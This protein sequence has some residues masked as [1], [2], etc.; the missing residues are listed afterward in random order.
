MI[1]QKQIN[2]SIESVKNAIFNCLPTP[3]DN[4]FKLT[5]VID[6]PML[7]QL[8][9]YITTVDLSKWQGVRPGTLRKVISWNGD[10]VIEELHLVFEGVTGLINQQLSDCPLNFLGLQL[11]KDSDSYHMGY[12]IDNSMI[13]V[14]IQVYLFDSPADSGTVFKIKEEEYLIPFVHNTG[15]VS[16]YV[17]TTCVPHK[18]DVHL[19]SADSNRYSLYAVWSKSEKI[20]QE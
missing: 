17:R 15:Y 4:L 13:D 3:T 11:W 18:V 2:S 6:Q 1:R 5:S 7:E 14:A 12:H 8:R 19:D 9:R 20:E 16:N 10:T